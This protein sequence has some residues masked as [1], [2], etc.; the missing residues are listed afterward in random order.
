MN[1]PPLLRWIVLG[2]DVAILGLQWKL[3]PQ[4][5]TFSLS[6]KVLTSKELMSLKFRKVLAD[7]GS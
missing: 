6:C 2:T 5:Q 3:N 4:K 1:L 7:L